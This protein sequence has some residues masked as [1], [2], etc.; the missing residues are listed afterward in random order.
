MVHLLTHS[1]RESSKVPKS[2]QLPSQVFPPFVIVRGTTAPH[3][4]GCASWYGWR[5]GLAALAPRLRW[6]HVD[7]RYRPP[8]K[9][10]GD[11]LFDAAAHTI[12]LFFYCY[13]N[14]DQPKETWTGSH[15]TVEFS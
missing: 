14:L 13:G 7:L 5:L 9:S 15:C 2:I 3:T 8:Q 11:L 4:A 12:G 6:H 1:G 10:P